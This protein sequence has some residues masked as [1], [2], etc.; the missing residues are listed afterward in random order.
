MSKT[1]GSV[2]LPNVDSDLLK[3]C[4]QGLK[5]ASLDLV[6]Q[7]DVSQA[8][9]DEA[10][11]KLNQHQKI[12]FDHATR[13]LDA[14]SNQSSKQVLA[15][16]DGPG[17]TGKTF[18]LNTIIHAFLCDAKTVVAVSSAGVSALL[19]HNGSTAHSAFAIPLSVDYNSTCGL[20]GKDSKSILLKSAHLVIWDE[21]SMQHKYCV[22][23]VDRSLK[24]IRGSSRPFG[25]LSVIFAGDFRQ[26]LPIVPGGTMY[27]QK[28][29]CLKSSYVWSQLSI[30]HLHENLRLKVSNE[31]SG[32]DSRKYADWL[33][34]IGNGDFNTAN[35]ASVSLEDVHVEFIPPFT[36]DP[37]SILTWLYDGLIDHIVEKRWDLLIKYYGS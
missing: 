13:T 4:P 21:I 22:E 17:G 2:G 33:L 14:C 29:A 9:L 7:V 18:L 8:V 24:H 25:G 6:A 26:T 1:L 32:F 3:R 20:T 34:K 35:T 16:L 10:V 37:H 5:G 12:F 19:L 36:Y 23:A 11:P 31:S 28:K 30:F 15:Y 27:D